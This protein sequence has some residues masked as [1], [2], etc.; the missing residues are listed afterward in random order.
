[1]IVGPAPFV[2][3]REWVAAVQ[4]GIAGPFESY[5]EQC[6]SL[7]ESAARQDGTALVGLVTEELVRPF[8]DVHRDETRAGLQDFLQR[9]APLA[10]YRPGC[11]DILEVQFAALLAIERTAI[12]AGIK[13]APE[14]AERAA[15]S[16]ID[17]IVRRA[18]IA[19]VSVSF[20]Q[21]VGIEDIDLCVDLVDVT[22]AAAS[23]DAIRS[24]LVL[25]V[26]AGGQVLF[27]GI[28]VSSSS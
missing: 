24:L 22:Q 27:D 21:L 5:L 15:E 12:G 2:L 18:A 13:A 19:P 16:I 20:R 23:V 26:S 10:L 9:A 25:R 3:R 4:R 28:A 14:S 8:L 11:G 1:M 17:K 6:A 7:D